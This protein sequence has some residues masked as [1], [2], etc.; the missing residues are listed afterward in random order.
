MGVL[1]A[2]RGVVGD[3]TFT[4][5]ECRN[6]GEKLA[7]DAEVCANCGADEIAFYEF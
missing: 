5:C 1:D 4:L 2:L 3:G 6:C 7:D